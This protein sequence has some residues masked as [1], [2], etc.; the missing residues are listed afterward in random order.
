MASYNLPG[1]SLLVAEWQKYKDEFFNALLLDDLSDADKRYF[2]SVGAFAIEINHESKG[3]AKLETFAQK[4][5]LFNS[6]NF[7]LA[8]NMDAFMRS[9]SVKDISESLNFFIKNNLLNESLIAKVKNN[10]TSLSDES[11]KNVTQAFFSHLGYLSL[12][13]NTKNWIFENA[14]EY[15]IEIN[16]EKEFSSFV[17][18]IRYDDNYEHSSLRSLNSKV[19]SIYDLPLFHY[20]KYISEADADYEKIKKMIVNYDWNHLSYP[21]QSL[22]K[23]N[24][25]LTASNHV[26]WYFQIINNLTNKYSEKVPPYLNE[27]INNELIKYIIDHGN[28]QDFQNFAL[29]DKRKALYAFS[30][31]DKDGSRDFEHTLLY[32]L[33]LRGKKLEFNDVLNFYTYQESSFQTCRADNSYVKRYTFLFKEDLYILKEVLLEHKEYSMLDSLEKYIHKN[34]SDD[35]TGNIFNNVENSETTHIQKNNKKGFLSFVHSFSK[36]FIF[37]QK[38]EKVLLENQKEENYIPKNHAEFVQSLNEY[39]QLSHEK[40]QFLIRKIKISASIDEG[41]KKEVCEQIESISKSSLMIEKILEQEYSV[42][43]VEEYVRYKSLTGRYFVRAVEQLLHVTTEAKTI[44]EENDLTLYIE[45]FREQVK[46]IN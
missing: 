23:L 29:I 36:M 2:V 37:N 25:L 40:R 13:Q 46:F 4:H 8:S 5:G 12:D 30:V 31:L 11:K 33:A 42:K 24:K 27:L 16:L 26:D 14:W 41:T 9:V 35:F 44:L 45:Q 32:Q 34:V 10:F 21:K 1:T 6:L 3:Y 39:A 18:F 38:E 43:N 19:E 20:M 7:N 22:E 17:K 15:K 28:Y